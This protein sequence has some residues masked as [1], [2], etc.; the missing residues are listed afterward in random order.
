M[1]PRKEN[2]TGNPRLEAVLFDMDGVITDTAEAHMMAW[3]RLF[4]AYLREQDPDAEPFS[5]S[6]YRRYVDGKPRFDGV[7]SFLQSR[8]IEVPFG[9]PEDDP[10]KETVCGLGNRKNGYFTEWL[11][12]NSATVFP[13]SRA[14][15]DEL[16]RAGI[17]AAV[18]SSSQ[19]AGDVLE[20][21]G[22]L[23]RFE[24]KVDGAD[25]A[26][27]GLPGKPDPAIMLRA[28]EQLGVSP[29][30]CAVLEDALAGVEAGAAGGF[31]QVVG[32]DREDGDELA[33]GGADI[34]VSDLAELA[35][36]DGPRLVARTLHG[37]PLVRDARD[38]F[39][40]QAKG[41]H[42]V[43]FLD[44]DGTLT[45]IVEKPEDATLGDGMR[46]A[47]SRLAAR[48]PV[49]IVSG[50][51][52]ADVQGFVEDDQLYYAGSHGF[53]LAGPDGWQEVVEKGKKF[54][55]ALKAAGDSLEERLAS[56]EGAW[57]ERKRFSLAVHF[58]Q[59]AQA[60]EE[61]VA[62]AVKETIAQHDELRAS[63]GKKVFDVKPRADWNKG[64]AVL[65]LLKRL[66]L[67]RADVLPIYVGDDTTD[68]DAF[69]A[70]SDRGL[71]VVVRDRDDR[72][73]SA[74]FSLEDTDDVER[75]LLWLANEP[76]AGA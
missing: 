56:V 59:V 25:M 10:E 1:A 3:K 6:D 21:A 16:E 62:D 70:L 13:G 5:A 53:D 64:R 22:V 50:R 55:P 73:T 69:R 2:T 29:D 35:V 67:D 75:F 20:S 72:R 51:D 44:Y 12:E 27:A 41:K 57:V 49:A 26:E 47:L 28:A 8:G 39:T 31:A 34:V 58:R 43:V 11:E 45:P 15:L 38:A 48:V 4:D 68:E 33:E 63:G 7:E 19:N 40:A 37:T 76:G 30:N 9:D 54:L 65:Y 61:T 24:V 46:T 14:L 60:E 52:L 42:L 74:R 36:G 17:R 71:G 18:F 66:E 23:E 32:I